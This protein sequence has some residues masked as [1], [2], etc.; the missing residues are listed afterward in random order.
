M[1]QFIVNPET[2]RRLKINSKK[3]KLVLNEYV[4]KLIGGSSVCSQFHE[5]PIKC[6]TSNDN[7]IPCVYTSRLGG[8][9][10][11]MR[12]N[13]DIN[14]VE[15][16]RDA[17]RK[18]TTLADKFTESATKMVQKKFRRKKNLKKFRNIVN[19][20][21]KQQSENKKED[22]RILE[23]FNKQMEKKIIEKRNARKLS[24]IE[25]EL[26]D[27]IHEE[28]SEKKTIEKLPVTKEFTPFKVSN[29]KIKLHGLERNSRKE[30]FTGRNNKNFIKLA[31]KMVNDLYQEGYIFRE[32]LGKGGFGLAL[33][34]FNPEGKIVAIKGIYE[35]KSS[36]IQKGIDVSKYMKSNIEKCGQSSAFI[37]DF[38]YLG[39]IGGLHY[40]SSEI[41]DGDLFDFIVTREGQMK[42]FGN[43]SKEEVLMNLTRQIIDGIHCLHSIGITH[44]DIKLENIFI[45][46]NPLQVKFADFDGVGI[47]ELEMGVSSTTGDYTSFEI[48]Y[49][50]ELDNKDDIFALGIAFL[51][52][53]EE[54]GLFE[55]FLKKNNEYRNILS[56]NL[57][58]QE[59]KPYLDN[60]INRSSKIPDIMKPYLIRMLSQY[61]KQRPTADELKAALE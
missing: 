56:P 57:W 12:K 52:I 17:S 26:S 59:I 49:P 41:T 53:Y 15:L 28:Q 4:K 13:L 30:L 55:L 32:F 37:L 22:I 25:E 19:Q 42:L 51:V 31:E 40:F 34:F 23:A 47:S 60:F 45:I 36:K 38:E 14:K 54:F 18:N 10:S 24:T 2:N 43:S 33:S 50:E 8:T 48:D 6:H 35:Y 11:K 1:Y 44:G 20:S 5:N 16:Y 7:G 3:G 58:N 39:L 29:E 9:C 27:F 46:A 61:K 21:I